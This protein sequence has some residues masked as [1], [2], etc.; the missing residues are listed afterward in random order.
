LEQ[1][2]IAHDQKDYSEA[3]WEIRNLWLQDNVT[4]IL[5]IVLI[6]GAGLLAVRLTNRKTRWLA[7]VDRGW[8]RLMQVRTLREVAFM[9][10]FIRHPADACYEIKA[11]K[12]VSMGTAWIIL[13]LLFLLYIAGILFTG[14]IFNS[15]IPEETILIKEALSI[16]LPI[17]IFVFANYLMSSLM[18]GEGTFRATFIN[19][20]G[21]LMPVFILYPIIIA[22]S[23]VITLNESF[24]YTMGLSVMFG[25]SGILVFFN[26]MSKK[27]TTIPSGRRSSIC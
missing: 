19:S 23:N 24:L 3:F 26:V 17:L 4:T 10:R 14:F 20:V 12:R 18:E 21:T 11:K 6:L 8:N 13:G 15:V 5:W 16:L 27:R 25:W 9:F 22:L 1:F 2:D 7:F